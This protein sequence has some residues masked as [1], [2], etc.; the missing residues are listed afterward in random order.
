MRKIIILLVIL[1]NSFLHGQNTSKY[2][3]LIYS[4][5]KQNIKIDRHKYFLKAIELDST[6]TI[7]DDLKL[8]NVFFNEY[9]DRHYDNCQKGDSVFISTLYKNDTFEIESMYGKSNEEK[10]IETLRNKKKLFSIKVNSNKLIGIE[11]KYYY[12]LIK[13]NACFGKLDSKNAI[14][15]NIDNILLVKNNIQEIPDF[16]LDNENCYKLYSKLI[17]Q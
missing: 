12:A 2:Y 1:T 13:S 11:I 9:S 6:L 3:L 15:Y 8:A 17:K 5:V 10:I 4:D 16:Y 14:K 7:K